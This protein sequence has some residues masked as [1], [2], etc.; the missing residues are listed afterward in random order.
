MFEI[1]LYQ[2]DFTQKLYLLLPNFYRQNLSKM[3]CCYLADNVV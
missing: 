3:F 2:K 1:I